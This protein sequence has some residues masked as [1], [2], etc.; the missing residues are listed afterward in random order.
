LIFLKISSVN[1][2]LLLF[3]KSLDTLAV[4]QALSVSSVTKLAS[5]LTYE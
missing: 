3:F 1:E 2:L 4:R 5:S